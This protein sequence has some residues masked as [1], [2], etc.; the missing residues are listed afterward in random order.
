LA[1]IAQKRREQLAP[2]QATA[3]APGPR[4]TELTL[5]QRVKRVE[6]VIEKLRPTLQADHGDIELVEIDNKTIYVDML[7]ACKGCAMEQATLGGIQQKLI[8]EFGEFLKVI[9]A[10]RMPLAAAGRSQ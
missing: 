6:A 5:P 4:F 8:E 3:P 2:E 7:G 9:P 10:S 1:R